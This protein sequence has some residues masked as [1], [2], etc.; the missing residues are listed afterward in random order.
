M[1]ENRAV[2]VREIIAQI[3]AIDSA[4]FTVGPL[5]FADLFRADRERIRIAKQL[6]T[7]S[8]LARELYI[9]KLKL[10]RASA[11]T[12][13]GCEYAITEI[14][15]SRAIGCSLLHTACAEQFDAEYSEWLGRS[16]TITEAGK[17]ALAAGER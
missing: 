8:D 11:T 6:A 3:V 4:G 17:A 13:A 9:E 2:S 5:Y 16:V 14:R 7:A 1:A 12:C 15:H 10:Y